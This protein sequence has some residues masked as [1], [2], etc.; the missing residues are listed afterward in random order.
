MAAAAAMSA[1]IERHRVLPLVSVLLFALLLRGALFAAAW[2]YSADLQTLHTGD[3]PTYLTP[4]E[5]LLADGTFSAGTIPSGT[6]SNVT[7]SGGTFSN[8]NSSSVAVPEIYRTPGYPLFLTA[9]LRAGHVELVTVA[10]QAV[11]SLASILLVY[12]LAW[13]LTA[14]STAA[15][16]A[17]LLVAMEPLSRFTN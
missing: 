2:H 9:G 12:H 8:T 16:L 1:K 6:F 15:L 14:S 7:S 10:L 3:T 5:S 4:A 13:K 17:S 11:L